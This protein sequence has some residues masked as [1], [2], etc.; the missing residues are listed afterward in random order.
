MSRKPASTRPL[1]VGDR[2]IVIDRT[3][4]HYGETGQVTVAPRMVSILG[5]TPRMWLEMQGD[6]TDY[7]VEPHQVRRVEDIR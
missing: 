2:V 3:H 5:Q 1:A 6:W 4:P 7:G